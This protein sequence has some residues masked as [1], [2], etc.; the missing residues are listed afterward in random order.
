MTEASRRLSD[1]LLGVSGYGHRQD[2]EPLEPPHPTDIGNA[3]RFARD[4]RNDVRYVHPWRRWLVWD[5][6]R[7]AM[8]DTGA[9]VRRAKATVLAIYAEAG[10]AERQDERTALAAH[11][12][13]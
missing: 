2:V 12:V 13:K 7:W 3:E 9:V 10:Y 8:D 5:G 11:A 4:H 6:R 1:E